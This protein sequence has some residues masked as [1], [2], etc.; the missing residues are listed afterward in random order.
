M[1][2]TTV[3]W[4]LALAHTIGP[5]VPGVAGQVSTP[6][7]PQATDPLERTTPRGSLS[8]FIQ[9]VDDE[10]YVL[11]SRYLQVSE[12]QRRSAE[13]LARDLKALMDRYF[14]EAITSISD[15]PD[16]ALDDGLPIDRERVGPLDINDTKTDITLV[17]VTDPQA[18]KVWLISSETLAL[19]PALNRS[20]ARTWI[21]RVS[22]SAL[23]N[24]ELFGISLAH[25]IV[26]VATLVIPFVLLAL[27]AAGLMFVVRRTVPDM[28]R[29]Y[30]LDVW[31]AATRWPAITVV[32][33]VVQL[34]M[35]RFLGYPLAFRITYAHIALIAAVIAMAWLLRRILTLGFARARNMVWG[36]DR[37]STQSLMLLGERLLKMLVVVVAILAILSIAGV[38][39]KTALAGIGIGGVALALGAQKT[40]EN[41]L[42]G[43]FLLSDRV[44]A[45]GDTC[46]I[47]NRVGTVE[48]ITLRSVRLRTVDQTLVSV[49]AGVLAQAG[50]ENFAS[51]QKIP[52]QTT[53]RLRYGTS[54]RQLRQILD[55]VRELL[56]RS[57]K[58]EQTSARIRLI[59]FGERALELELFAY[60][61]TA[62]FAEFLGLR[63]GLLLEIASIVEA[64]GTAFAQPTELIFT[65][66]KPGMAV[67]PGMARE[68]AVP[69][70]M[71]LTPGTPAVR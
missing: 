41:F 32:V 33:L 8:A 20:V 34:T 42:G 43:V 58:I 12:S 6:A 50:I 15:S 24:R 25:W 64:A 28:G 51:R 54:T 57:P 29:R 13:P 40:V 49:P 37:T 23:L 48:D 52:V 60:M 18:G 4:F 35:L 5:Q 69:D 21:E 68:S 65:D 45:V 39:T 17:R 67:A 38:N 30:D 66:G 1:P 16:G 11:A 2:L 55:G 71:R 31:Y 63:E 61:L 53:L 27:L 59:N 7:P 26:L 44:L 9:A 22:P 47:S 10:D 62:D 56:A 36:K 70:D 19:V 3:L 14:S 46:S